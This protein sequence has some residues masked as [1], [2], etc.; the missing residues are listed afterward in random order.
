MVDPKTLYY[1]IGTRG[2]SNFMK[3]LWAAAFV[4]MGALEWCLL[5]ITNTYY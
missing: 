2:Q 4:S 3:A 5:H 1:K